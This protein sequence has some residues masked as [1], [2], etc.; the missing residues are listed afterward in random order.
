MTA[1]H[2]CRGSAYLYTQSLDNS[3]KNPCLGSRAPGEY[4]ELETGEPER[5]A[6]LRIIDSL[7]ND[8]LHWQLGTPSLDYR[9]NLYGD[10]LVTM[11]PLT[12]DDSGRV[13]PIM[14]IFNIWNEQRHLA[15]PMLVDAGQLM[16]RELSAD[17]LNDISRLKQVMSW[18]PL[19]IALH[20]LI[21]SRR[22]THD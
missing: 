5:A 14:L 2:N 17:H 20:T 6:L 22:A 16:Q 10:C 21:F 4:R 18:P 3:G 13:A 9:V 7:S 15:A 11:R 19:L 1:Q 12:R 8:G